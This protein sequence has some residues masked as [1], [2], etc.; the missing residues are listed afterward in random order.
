MAS[1]N[2][3]YSFTNGTPANA[4]E[5]NSNFVAVKTFADSEVIRADGAVKAGT[6]S[7]ADAAVTNAKLNNG[8]SGDVALVT[9]SGSAPASNSVGKNGDIWIVV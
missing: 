1:L 3:P 2:I 5:V 4:T 8:S 9:V 7:I 6:V